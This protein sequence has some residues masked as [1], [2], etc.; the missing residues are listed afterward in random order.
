MRERGS[1]TARPTE[2]GGGGL[3]IGA[4]PVDFGASRRSIRSISARRVVPIRSVSSRFA[5]FLLAFRADSVAIRS[6]FGRFR[7]ISA[8]RF[9]PIRS[10]SVDLDCCLCRDLACRSCRF[11]L[12]LVSRFGVPV[13]PIWTAACVAIWRAGRVASVGGDRHRHRQRRQDT[14]KP[15][16]S[17]GESGFSY[18]KASRDLNLRLVPLANT[19]ASARSVLLGLAR[20][21]R[22]VASIRSRRV[23]SVSSRRSVV[24][25]TETDNEGKTQ[26]SPMPQS[27]NRASAIARRRAILT[28]D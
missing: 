15:D 5:D 22:R 26:K 11:G 10:V 25:D 16:S 18:R 23:A 6:R 7:S 9:V 8:R 17:I 4:R 20:R 27:G 1:N 21:F 24:T 19:R 12:L 3:P 13:V 2:K 14:K 28:F